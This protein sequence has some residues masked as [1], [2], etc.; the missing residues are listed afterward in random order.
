[1]KRIVFVCTA[2]VT[3]LGCCKHEPARPAEP[4]DVSVVITYKLDTS[5]GS[6][7]TKATDAEVFDM[8]Y[9]KMKT[10]ELTAPSY[11]LTFTETTTGAKY[12]FHGNWKDKDLITI[13]TGKYKV[14][15]KSTADG[16]HIQEIASL[17]FNEEI[18]IS[19]SSTSVTLNAL[20]DCFLLAFGKSDITSMENYFWEGSREQFFVMN[21]YYYVFVK[22]LMYQS[23]YKESAYIKGT[24]SNGS[25]FKI[26][27]GKA[28]FEKGKYYI[29][30]DVSGSFEL[31][32]MEAGI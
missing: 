18:E 22:D 4:Q 24:R 19:T 21:N 28:N 12:E 26:M 25:T 2:I 9:Q 29:Y 27:T 23:A 17:M 3:L 20:Y 1:M 13:R 14:E 6:N 7:M 31:P 8:F 11:K 15:G 32:K 5:K 10:G 16:E 30:S